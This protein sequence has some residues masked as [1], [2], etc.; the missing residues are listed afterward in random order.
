MNH[1]SAAITL[2]LIFLL[3]GCSHY[4]IDELLSS[5]E[6][7]E[8]DGREYTLKAALWRNFFP[9]SPPTGLY[10]IVYIIAS[11]SLQF[12]SSLDVHH[13]W[14][15]M[16]NDVWDTDLIDQHIPADQPYILQAKTESEGPDWGPEIYVNAVVEISD[17]DDNLYLLR[18]DSQLI[19]RLD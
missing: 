17:G 4:S 7:L 10:G 2:F 18:A 12:L 11:D 3:V 1:N 15:I 19:G 8:I 5:P 9:P 6:A 14:V 16:D 13:L